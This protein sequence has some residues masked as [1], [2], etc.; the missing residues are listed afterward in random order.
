[1]CS[2]LGGT[3]FD[4]TALQIYH[5]AKSRGRDFTGLIEVNG[6]WI[7]NHRATP[8]NEVQFA[9]QNQPFG[10]NGN[11][12]VHNGTI[13]NDEELGNEVGNIDSKV[14]AKIARTETLE[15]FRDSLLVLKGSFA[16][17]CI[18]AK[19]DI[20]LAV[21]YKPLFYKEVNG[22]FYFSSLKEHLG[23]CERVEPYTCMNLR[24][25]ESIEIPRN[26]PDNALII[27]SGGLDS[28]SLIGYAVKKHK[29]VVL[30]HFDYGCK[31]TEKEI[32]A[33][34][35]IGEEMGL[36]YIIQN[37][38]YSL[39]QGDSPLFN[40]KDITNG[41]EGVEYASEWVF[42]RNLIMLSNAIGYAEANGFGYVYL[43][44]NL[45]ESG[46]YPDNE[47]QFILDFNGILW[48]AVNNGFKVEIKMPLGNLMKKEIV[49]FGIDNNSPIHLSWSCY[50]NKNYHCGNCGP[51]YMRK[52]A[53]K[54]SN[55][56]D[57][58]IYLDE[59]N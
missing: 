14:I 39:M 6:N 52:E 50:N 57:E 38:N 31:A 51:C 46:A 23:K 5:K 15:S 18:T 25:N 35:R 8:T 30:L 19:G 29:K 54:R 45:E 27:C 48:G 24:T 42:A 56:I 7:C 10:E 11:Y 1:M 3:K 40:D 47:E 43:G 59:N 53:F 49:Q 36:N 37:I 28:T 12:I 16:I 26:Q 22:E 2:I 21:N 17:G 41:K 34:K 44:N 4:D 55:N 20:F 33:I 13:A 58:T 9:N 32:E